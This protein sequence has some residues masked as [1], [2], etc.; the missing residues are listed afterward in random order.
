MIFSFKVNGL[1]KRP[2]EFNGTSQIGYLDHFGIAHCLLISGLA[3]L[4]VGFNAI[5]LAVPLASLA[6]FKCLRVFF[7]PLR[8]TQSIL[9]TF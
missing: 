8:T 6:L 2:V 1:A 9:L 7:F 3:L 4:L 5:V